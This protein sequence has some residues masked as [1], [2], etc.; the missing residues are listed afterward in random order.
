M[1]TWFYVAVALFVVIGLVLLLRYLF[2][3]DTR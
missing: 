2:P 3:A 1:P